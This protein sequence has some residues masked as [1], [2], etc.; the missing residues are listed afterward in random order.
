MIGAG[1]AG[2]PALLAERNAANSI[3]SCQ[4]FTLNPSSC[5]L[6][7]AVNM[8]SCGTLQCVHAGQREWLSVAS[9]GPVIAV[10]NTIVPLADLYLLFYYNTKLCK[11]VELVLY[12]QVRVRLQHRVVAE[13]LHRVARQWQFTLARC[14]VTVLY[15]YPQS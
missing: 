7:T 9:V 1:V 10:S 2:P 6:E 3:A 12:T 4:V 14:L 5:L 11:A 13:L 8:S 15:P